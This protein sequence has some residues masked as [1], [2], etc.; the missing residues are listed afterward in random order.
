MIPGLQNC[1]TGI[2]VVCFSF[3]GRHSEGSTKFANGINQ[4]AV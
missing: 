1:G 2:Y 4:F 3:E